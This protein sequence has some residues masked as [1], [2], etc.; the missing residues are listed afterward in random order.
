MNQQKEKKYIL[1]IDQG[2]TSSRCIL[3]DKAGGIVGLAQH[4]FGQI[5]PQPGWVEH[6]PMEILFSQ[7][8]AI[9]EAVRSSGVDP[10]EIAAAGITNQRETAIL[11]DRETGQPVYN[12][13]VWQCRRT[14]DFCEGLQKQGLG[15]QITAK[16]GLLIDAYFSASKIRWVL[17]HVPR[18]RQ[19]AEEG[20]LL[21]G[22]VDTWLLWNLSGGTCHAT[23]YTNASRTMLFNLDT[24]SWDAELCALFDIPPAI[25]PQVLPSSAYYCSFS[26][27]GRGLEMLKGLPICGVAGDQ[28][29]ALFGQACFEPGQAKNTY[30]TGCFLL[31]NTGARRVVSQSRLL[32][33]IAWAVDGSVEYAL[34]GSVFNGGSTVQWLRDEL[35]IIDS[36]PECSQLAETVEDAGGLYIVP[37]FTGLGAPYWDMHA[38]GTI[39]GISRGTGRAQL[40]RAVIESIAYQVRDLIEAMQ[41]DSGLPLKK[42]RADGGASRSDVLL[43]F[44]ADLLSAQI[45]RP[46]TVESTAL[47]AAYLAGLASG[48]WPDREALLTLRAPGRVFQPQMEEEKRNRLYAGWQKAVE[49][50]R[51]FKL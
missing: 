16:T 34:E 26:G 51:T 7:T 9:A 5:F 3:F 19:L 42:L 10:A 6:D 11:W 12:A 13:I 24:L 15:A 14:A 4:E 31:L 27:V 50:A 44:Q 36:A 22:T 48:F 45:E 43:Q 37:A 20:R 39:V 2:T 32:S 33:T 18:A 29:A 49:T 23:D 30:G 41:K 46:E 47:G 38:K 1:A 35:R 8:L 21:F 17:D 40:A 28:H 25:L